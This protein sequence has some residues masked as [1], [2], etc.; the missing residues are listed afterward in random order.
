MKINQP[1]TFDPFSK[2]D[3]NIIKG[4]GILMIMFHNFFHLIKPMIGENEFEFSADNFKRFI[5]FTSSD[6]FNL[7]RF[8]S[9]YLGHYGVQLFI[10]ISSYGLFLGYR[11]KNIQWLS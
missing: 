7:F 4:L 8:A 1:I 11:N 5:H 6:P 9:S 10:F 2:N 3:T